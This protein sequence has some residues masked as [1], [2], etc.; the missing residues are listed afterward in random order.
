MN[1]TPGS[2]RHTE[3]TMCDEMR[4]PLSEWVGPILLRVMALVAMAVIAAPITLILILPF[5]S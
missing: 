3:T 5:T 4:D 1:E 2:P